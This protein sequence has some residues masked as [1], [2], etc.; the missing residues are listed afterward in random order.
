[1]LPENITK[2]H[3]IKIANVLAKIHQVSL[4]LFGRQQPKY[5]AIPSIELVSLFEK[6][7][8]AGM[9]YYPMLN[10][11]EML[12]LQISQRFAQVI[13]ALEKTGLIS[14]T[15][16]DPKNVLWDSLENPLLIDW[17]SARA[18][19]AT[20]D[21]IQLALDWTGC[22][23]CS[24]NMPDFQMLLRTF[25]EAG[26]SIDVELLED[27]LWAILGN[28]LNWLAFNIRKSLDPSLDHDENQM[29][30]FQVEST[31]KSILYLH[32]NQ[33]LMVNVAKL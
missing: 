31:L 28:S 9:S 16:L 19:N 22:P 8:H 15:D 14:H 13:P 23:S 33:T 25:K 29:A 17:E 6:A 10:E 21:I 7:Q 5:E 11:H 24:I 1:L 30:Q 32:E 4:S 3:L 18:I 12:L 20:H 27:V 26:G 2:E